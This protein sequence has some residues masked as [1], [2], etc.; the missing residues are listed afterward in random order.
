MRRNTAL[1][2]FGGAMILLGSSGCGYLAAG[3]ER[4][5]GRQVDA[6]YS[7]LAEKRVAVVV[8]ADP[9]TTNE[10]SAARE[11]ISS[12]LDAE[13]KRAIPTIQLVDYR[14]VVRWQNQTIHWYALTEQD[15]GK[16]FGVDRL[17]YLELLDYRTKI[18]GA[19]GYVQGNIR[20]LCKISEIGGAGKVV[21]QGEVEAAYPPDGPLDILS[22]NEIAVRTRTL[23]AFAR[24]LVGCLH[25]H[26]EIDPGVRERYGR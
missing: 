12:F 24:K 4:Q 1:R 3:N 2:L 11:E 18:P 9:A 13:L 21:W 8:Y 7:G 6:Q 15:I 26:R 22:L 23:E 16:H 25:T 5:H 19:K 17:V 10:F 20:A 14:E